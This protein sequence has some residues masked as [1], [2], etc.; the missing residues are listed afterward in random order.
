MSK[1]F[2]RSVAWGVTIATTFLTIVPDSIILEKVKLFDKLTDDKNLLID[3]IGILIA[4][5]FVSL[6]LNILFG[7]LRCKTTI[8]GN[9]YSI[10]VKYGDLFKC[11]N[12]QKVIPFDE[13]FTTK[14][15]MAPHEIKATSICGQYLS[16]NSNLDV[17]KLIAD[18][19]LN[20]AEEKSK[21]NN[22]TK[23]ESGLIV[24]F[25]DDLLLAFAK[26]NAD[27]RAYFPTREAYLNSLAVMWSEIHKYYQQKDI[28]IP[29]LGGG[30]T[31]IG[32]K[33]PTQQELVDLII[34]SYRLFAQKIMNPQKLRIICRRKDDISLSKIGEAI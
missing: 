27:G 29:V 25:G 31:S 16:K 33:K 5:F 30:L 24:P 14:I 6:L 26:L 3:R 21:F 10:Q 28:C 22:Q 19:G 20:P 2:K 34:E 17:Q 11:K 23:Y 9:G 7:R 8:K 32:E 18:A 15:G 12:C 1:F 4:A 13:C